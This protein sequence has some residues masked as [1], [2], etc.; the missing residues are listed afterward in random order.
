SAQ[1]CLAQRLARLWAEKEQAVV[2]I[3]LAVEPAQQLER[4][5]RER[6]DMLA[7]ALHTLARD[8]PKLLVEVDLAPRCLARFG[9]ACC[10]E[11]CEFQCPRGRAFALAQLGHERRHVVVVQSFEVIDGSDPSS[12]GKQLTDDVPRSRI[13]A[14]PVAG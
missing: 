11:D 9:A 10:S 14:R 4:F 13:V 5:G 7:G 12:G 6:D 2:A 3:T 1:R 8:A